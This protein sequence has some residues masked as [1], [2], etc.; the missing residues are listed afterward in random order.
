MVKRAGTGSPWDGSRMMLPEHKLEIFK[1]MLET[2]PSGPPVTD[3]TKLEEIERM[4]GM[5]LRTHARIKLV[6][7]DGGHQKT[8]SG[9]VTSIHTHSREVKLQWREDYRWISVD[10]IMEIYPA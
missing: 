9:F 6:L 2:D 1:T 5:S 10:S 3:E 7:R 8:L 4:L